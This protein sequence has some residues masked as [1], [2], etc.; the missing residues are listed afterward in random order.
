MTGSA[1]SPDTN[2]R[3]GS[4]P[5]VPDLIASVE[6][7]LRVTNT[8]PKP[9]IWT[10]SAEPLLE[11]AEQESPS[12][13][14]PRLRHT[15]ARVIRIGVPGGVA[16]VD[17]AAIGAHRTAL[18]GKLAA[19]SHLAAGRKPARRRH[20]APPRDGGSVRREDGADE[21]RPT[22]L[23]RGADHLRDGSV[24]HDPAWWDALDQAQHRLDVLVVH[25]ADCG[26]SIP[27]RRDDLQADGAR[28]G[29]AWNHRT[30]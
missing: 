10:A 1:N 25:G 23:Q 26:G 17:P 18:R 12:T 11:P 16:D 14:Q 27:P 19:G 28:A 30:R 20:H 24:R 8:N 7:Y 15:L 9:L 22:P 3:R 29:Q 2:T 13:S 21:P 5:S 6:D 4:L